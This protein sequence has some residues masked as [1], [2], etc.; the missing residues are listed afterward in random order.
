M[1]S[2]LELF[3]PHT[4][5]IFD[6]D[7]TLLDSLWIWQRV[8]EAFFAA[9]GLS[10]PPD[11]ADALHALTFREV[12][13]YTIARLGLRETPEAVMAEWT[14]TSLALYQNEVRLK[15]GARE[16][17]A[18]LRAR[19]V[20]LAVAT[21]LTT[22]VLEAALRH[23]GILTWFQALT[24]AD[25]VPRGKEYPDIYQLTAKKLGVPPAQCVA[26]DDVAKALVG[27]RAAG[28]TACAV[29]EP[30]SGQNWAA[31]CRAAQSHILSWRNELQA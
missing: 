18:A 4:A 19:G 13:E 10:V 5:A 11:Y 28:V 16:Y 7:G 1:H 23:N 31:M 20:T 30:L 3:P 27:M 21:N 22:R 24:S 6:L 17:L 29:Y 14:A 12:A 8:D 9:R 25:E 26:Y 15:P 2:S